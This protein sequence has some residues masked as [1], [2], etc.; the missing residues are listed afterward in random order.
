MDKLRNKYI[1]TTETIKQN[2]R[3][4]NSER[5]QAV[6]NMN[7]MNEKMIE[8]DLQPYRIAS[9]RDMNQES[10][11]NVKEQGRDSN[12]IPGFVDSLPPLLVINATAATTPQQKHN[13]DNDNKPDE[14]QN[15]QN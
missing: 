12:D 2:K 7:N 9:E 10:N 13:N 15:Q 14:K 11:A 3:I 4:I 8:L 6:I 5:H 1:N